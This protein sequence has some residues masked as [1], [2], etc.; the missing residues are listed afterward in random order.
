METK[1]PTVAIENKL[2][3]FG[4][5]IS[6]SQIKREEFK[7][8]QMCFKCYKLEIYLTK[9]CPNNQTLKC[10]ECVR[11]DYIWKECKRERK[12]SV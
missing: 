1:I 8:I 10:S 11:D 12:K 9:N 6:R 4:V 3:L 5:K 7:G 2:L